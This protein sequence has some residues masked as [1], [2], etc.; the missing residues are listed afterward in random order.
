MCEFEKDGG[1]EKVM[2]YLGCSKMCECR[3]G[4]WPEMASNC[5][6]NFEIH[7]ILKILEFFGEFLKSC[8]KVAIY[9]LCIQ[10]LWAFLKL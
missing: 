5:K 1:F 2:I 7:E 6:I 4:Y 9:F 3:R 8:R 10:F